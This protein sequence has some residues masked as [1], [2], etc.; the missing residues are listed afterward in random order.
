MGGF[1][2]SDSWVPYLKAK[3]CGSRHGRWA[4]RTRVSSKSLG[5]LAAKART[6]PDLSSGGSEYLPIKK[7]TFWNL[8]HGRMPPLR[9]SPL[10]KI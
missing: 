1:S 6:A 5:L 8:E 7:Y 2:G 10:P 3:S 4:K 9:Q